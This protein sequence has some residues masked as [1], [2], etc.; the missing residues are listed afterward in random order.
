MSTSDI[1]DPISAENPPLALDP[2][3]FWPVNVSRIAGIGGVEPSDDA[4]YAFHTI[5]TELPPG[6]ARCTLRFT[7]LAATLGM[8]TVRINAL[9]AGPEPRAETIKTWPIRLP[10]LAKDG[11][12]VVVSF[13][14]EPGVRYAILGHI[15]GEVDAAATAMEIDV[16]TVERSKFFEDQLSGVQKSVFGQ[17]MFR[18]A[19]R[20]LGIGRATLADPVSQTCT[21]EQFDEPAYAE[22]LGRL[23]TTVHRHRKQWEFVYILRVLERYGMLKQGSTGLGFGVGVEPLP[24]VMAA[25]GC[26]VT[27]TDLPAD[28]ERT[29]DWSATNQHADGAEFLR[30]PTICPDELFD[31]CVKFRT[32]DMNAIPA[33]LTD[34]D[35]TWSSC[36]LEHLGSIEAG[37]D[38][39]R[40]SVDCLKMGGIAVHT[41]ELNLTSNE[42]TLDTG[43]TVLFRRQDLERLAVDLVSRGHYVA[44]L[45]F[46]LGKG[47]LDA[48]VDVPPYSQD[49]HLKLALANYV[50][51][52]FGI[53]VRRGDR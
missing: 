25:A 23:H 20:M 40:N 5:Y 52:S 21:A 37:L 42:H 19:G 15:Y 41:T 36:A 27:A 31:Q 18:R 30:H 12:Q 3:A 29:R 50:T 14:A 46:D 53:I 28:D 47:P 4:A 6:D 8:L 51:T 9:P 33:D 32:V 7:D 2:F 16:E 43:G 1:V 10:A 34:F 39:I 17:R 22:M 48:H 26:M 38:F 35:F 44:Q 45:K 49:N 13:P 11:G 24:A